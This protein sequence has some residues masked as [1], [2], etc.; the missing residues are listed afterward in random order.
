M[1][2]RE[3]PRTSSGSTRPRSTVP[4]PE[5]VLAGDVA[6]LQV[7]GPRHRLLTVRRVLVG[8]ADTFQVLRALPGLLRHLLQV[9]VLPDEAALA[10]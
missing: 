1:A 6:G 9:V 3:R 4:S 8:G 7:R 5:R 2:S 10:R